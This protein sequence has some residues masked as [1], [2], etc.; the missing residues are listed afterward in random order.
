VVVNT[1]VRMFTRKAVGKAMK[2][3]KSAGGKKGTKKAGG[4]KRRALPRAK[5]SVRGSAGPD[6][7]AGAK[8]AAEEAI[9]TAKVTGRWTR[10]RPGRTA[11]TRTPSR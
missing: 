10:G 8:W 5:R 4:A 2:A 9:T 6:E 7:E 3:A 1:V 11:M